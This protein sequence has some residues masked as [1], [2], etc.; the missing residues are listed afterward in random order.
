M[1]VYKLTLCCPDCGGDEWHELKHAE[2]GEWCCCGCGTVCEVA[3]MEVE[4]ENNVMPYLNNWVAELLEYIENEENEDDIDKH[5][6]K[7]ILEALE[8]V[9]RYIGE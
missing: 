8:C 3:E 9:R 1:S 6:C 2:V 4:Q 5:D 7:V